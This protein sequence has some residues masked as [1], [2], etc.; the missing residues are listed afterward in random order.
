MTTIKF[1]I[2]FVESMRR[3]FLESKT[4]HLYMTHKNFSLF[5][6]LKF[7]EFYTLFA[8][9]AVEWGATGKTQIQDTKET[10]PAFL[11]TLYKQ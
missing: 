3:V 5:K 7:I 10:G 11:P 2:K 8:L 1:V 6:V 9:H 4:I